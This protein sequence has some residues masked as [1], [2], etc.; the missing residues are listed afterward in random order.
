MPDLKNE[1]PNLLFGMIQRLR[2][3][4]AQARDDLARA[5]DALRQIEGRCLSLQHF[6]GCVCGACAGLAAIVAIAR[7]GTEE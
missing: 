7:K 4:H 2:V 6:P 3:E 1:H 5:L